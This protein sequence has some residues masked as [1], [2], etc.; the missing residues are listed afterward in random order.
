MVG[1]EE[2]GD[3]LN[4][5]LLVHTRGKFFEVDC[6]FDGVSETGYQFDVDIGFDESVRNLFDHSIEGLV[7]SAC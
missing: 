5:A 4:D 3:F 6:L 1:R 2:N 7:R